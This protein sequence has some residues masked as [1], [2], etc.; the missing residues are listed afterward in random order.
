MDTY[1]TLIR[2]V[3]NFSVSKPQFSGFK[4][5]DDNWFGYLLEFCKVQVKEYI[6]KFI[7]NY[8]DLYKHKTVSW[9]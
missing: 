8:Q 9:I 5:G 3:V 7:L 2:Q 6:R 4:V 1:H